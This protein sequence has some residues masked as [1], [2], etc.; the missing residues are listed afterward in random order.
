M[1]ARIAGDMA[2]RAAAHHRRAALALESRLTAKQRALLDSELGKWLM[3]RGAAQALLKYGNAVIFRCDADDAA[4]FDGGDQ[5]ATPVRP[6]PFLR[7]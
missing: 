2:L 5:D 3:E 6:V 7:G 1:E 4:L